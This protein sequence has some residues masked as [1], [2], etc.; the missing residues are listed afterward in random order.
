MKKN[1]D[2]F[3]SRLFLEFILISF[4][5]RKKIIRIIQA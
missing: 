1:I 4:E 5:V 2:Q 3:L